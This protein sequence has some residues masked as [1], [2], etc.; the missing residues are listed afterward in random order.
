MDGNCIPQYHESS[1]VGVGQF[2]HIEEVVP[3]MSGLRLT[4]E[5]NG[6]HVYY[7]LTEISV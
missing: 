5:C 2:L 6:D 3:Q 4:T 7:G 1:H